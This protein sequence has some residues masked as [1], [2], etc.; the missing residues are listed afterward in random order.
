MAYDIVI[1]GAGPAGL[2]AAIYAG[3][4]K[5]K[6]IVLESELVGGWVAKSHII[7]NYPGRPDVSGDDLAKTIEKQVKKLGIEIKYD[8]VN[9]I[10]KNGNFKVGCSSGKTYEGKTVLIATGASARKLGL[11]G[12][13]EFLG[14]GVSYCAICDAPLFKDKVVAVIGGGDSAAK[15]ALLIAEHSK[16]V[17]I[18]HRRDEFRAEA[19]LVDEMKGKKNLEMVLSYVPVKI[20]GDKMVSKLVVKSKKDESL[21]ELSVDGVFIEVGNTPAAVLAQQVGAELTEQGY[22]KVNKLQ[23]TNVPGIFAAGDVT[24]FPLK[25]IVCATGQGAQV[26]MSASAYIMKNKK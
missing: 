3:R 24:D 4:K 17:Y 16:K 5:M 2:T 19:L 15:A 21:K 23:E 9:K 25:Q 10:E 12:E 18:I 20:E 26:A 8:G 11:P 14:K 1:V 13:D 22:I 6:V 7:Q